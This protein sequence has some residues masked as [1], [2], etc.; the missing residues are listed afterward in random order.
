MYMWY[1]IMAY[2]LTTTIQE[3]HVGFEDGSLQTLIQLW[4]AAKKANKSDPQ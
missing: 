2:K 4:E 3:R 1:G